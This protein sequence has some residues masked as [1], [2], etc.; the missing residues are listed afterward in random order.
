MYYYYI[1]TFLSVFEFFTRVWYLFVFENITEE[2]K[3]FKKD[4]GHI[5]DNVQMHVLIY[6]LEFLPYN[7][8]WFFKTAKRSFVEKSH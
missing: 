8:R 1:T 6:V 7:N 5:F 3:F 2:N 4:L